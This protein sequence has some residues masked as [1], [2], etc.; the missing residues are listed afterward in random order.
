MCQRVW[1][2]LSK[3]EISLDHIQTV[4][5]ISKIK[6]SRIYLPWEEREREQ[7]TWTFWTIRNRDDREDSFSGARYLADCL[8]KGRCQRSEDFNRQYHCCMQRRADICRFIA[9]AASP[10]TSL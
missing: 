4:A 10:V 1:E 5:S 3:P 8:P 9:S 6:A 2:H 7:S